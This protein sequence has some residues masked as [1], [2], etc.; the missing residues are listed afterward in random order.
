MTIFVLIIILIGGG[1]I[2]EFS[3]GASPPYSSGELQLAMYILILPI[4]AIQISSMYSIAIFK[5]S[6]KGIREFQ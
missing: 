4:L 5:I 1:M 2:L 3:T 6:L